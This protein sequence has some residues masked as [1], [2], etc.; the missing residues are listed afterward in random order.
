MA[1]KNRFTYF[2]EYAAARG[3][4]GAL[5]RLPRRWGVPAGRLLGRLAGRV[6][7]K[8]SRLAA[9][10]MRLAFPQESADRIR[11]WVR[12]CWEGLGEF[13]WEFARL[14]AISRD[15]YFDA[16]SVE[17]LEN[18]RSAHALG[19]G[20]LCVAGHIA[21]WE[22]TTQFISF[23]GF[24]LAAVARRMKNPYVNDFVTR[25]RERHG[26]R[27]FMH[28]N[29][30]RESIRWLK[31]GNVLGVLID[32]RITD[33]GARVPFLGRPAHTTTMPALLAL[34]L[35]CPVIPIVSWREEGRLRIRVEPAVDLSGLSGK[36]E[37]ILAATVRL[38]AVI[39]RWV[40]ER[41]PS[42]LWIHN[43]WK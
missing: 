5:R 1:T 24:P 14:P 40:R 4:L 27:V 21:N 28:K 41:P 2:L 7:S 39:E 11:R 42:W 16:V 33:G 36:P 31:D 35:G 29:A 6:L 15:D 23:S 3:L 10:N 18:L 25:I 37:D 43:R 19:K 13:V 17:G 34:R 20:V 32:Q 38:N 12:E 9:E 26:A 30:V 22:M 8:R